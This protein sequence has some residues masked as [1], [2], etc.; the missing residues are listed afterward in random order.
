[1]ILDITG[2]ELIPGNKGK[3]CPGN[4]NHMD[5]SGNLIEC[6]CDEC[7]YMIC[8]H[9]DTAELCNKCSDDMCPRASDR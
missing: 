1:M 3:D 2:I 6:C 9:G 5:K 4:G 7:D 8:C